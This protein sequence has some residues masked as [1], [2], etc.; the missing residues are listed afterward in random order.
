MSAAHVAAAEQ[1][2]EAGSGQEVKS[3][4][5]Q[6]EVPRSLVALR[7]APLSRTQPL[8][9]PR[10]Y[11]P[12]HTSATLLTLP[13]PQRPLLLLHL[14]ACLPERQAKVQAERTTQAGNL[15]QQVQTWFK[16]HLN[17]L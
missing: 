6:C 14:S 12:L 3:C 4:S 1:Q 10:S 13:Q 15:M 9:L 17:I 8:L 5:V 11:P 16:L 2:D 7:L